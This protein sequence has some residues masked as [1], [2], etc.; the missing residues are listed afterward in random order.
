MGGFSL[1]IC[2]LV[3]LT[4]YES[5]LLLFEF[6]FLFQVEI[7]SILALNR[8]LNQ[9]AMGP[10]PQLDN[11]MLASSRARV[12]IF[13]LLPKCTAVL[14]NGTHS[15]LYKLIRLQVAKS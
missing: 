13:R 2:F 7:D 4:I 3:K 9:K 6:A 5:K 8:D 15:E 11:H 1:A 14:L 10:P 12:R